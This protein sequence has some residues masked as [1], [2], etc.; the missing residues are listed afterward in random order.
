MFVLAEEGTASEAPTPLK[1]G[2]LGMD[3]TPLFEDWEDSVWLLD[4]EVSVDLPAGKKTGLAI[5]LY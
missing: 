1:D 5:L 4:E 3:D 2:D